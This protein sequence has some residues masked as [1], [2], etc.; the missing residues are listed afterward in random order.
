MRISAPKL[1]AARAIARQG[2]LDDGVEPLA[3]WLDAH[4][5]DGLALTLEADGSGSIFPVVFSRHRGA[6]GER[7]LTPDPLLRYDTAEIRRELVDVV[8]SVMS[9]S[10]ARG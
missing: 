7:A 1:R 2:P 3:H 9:G 8:A 10:P 4:D 5:G 6:L